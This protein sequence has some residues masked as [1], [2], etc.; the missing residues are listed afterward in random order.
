M[1]SGSAKRTNGLKKIV[2]EFREIR[3]GA[4]LRGLTFRQLINE[5]R[6]Y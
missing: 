6:R 1:K 4:R 5:G 2:R 3:K